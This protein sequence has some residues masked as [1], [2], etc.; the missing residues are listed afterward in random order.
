M[1]ISEQLRDSQ[2][3]ALEGIARQGVMSAAQGLSDMVGRRVEIRAPRVAVMGISE[4]PEI[5][6]S[7]E[8]T[9]VGVY[10]GVAGDVSGHIILLF[11]PD[12][13]RRLVDLLMDLPEGTTMALGPMERSAL[14]EV[15]NLTGSFFLNALAEM[16][17]LGSQPTPPAVMMDMGAAV[18]DVPLVALAQSSEQVLLINTVFVE[19]LRQIGG[20]FL[21]M[22]DVAS[23]R[24]ILEVVDRQWGSI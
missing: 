12:E 17:R 13:A 19:N 7:P 4:V 22:P 15:G 24:A 2:Y 20:V 1:T 5:L 6:A 8:D 16:T 11:P 10:L 18:L 14:G 23:L 3:K 21:V 9:V